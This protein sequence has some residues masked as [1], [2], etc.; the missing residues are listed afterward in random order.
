MVAAAALGLLLAS[1]VAKRFIA[2]VQTSMLHRPTPPDMVSGLT[3]RKLGLRRSEDR[4][5]LFHEERGDSQSRSS[6]PRF[7]SRDFAD[8]THCTEELD[9]IVLVMIPESSGAG[10]HPRDVEAQ[11]QE[12]PWWQGG[13]RVEALYVITGVLFVA[14]ACSA[15]LTA[16]VG[17]GTE[18][19][20]LQITT[21][22]FLG[23]DVLA[24]VVLLGVIY[25][26]SA[27]IRKPPVYE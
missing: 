27:V 11:R 23:L 4:L 21:F 12:F 14:T 16:T 6:S 15:I 20:V 5:P 9:E 17:S 25:W 8:L 1:L 13:R 2:C 24:A 10:D 7:A 26:R 3:G 18:I 22:A 19:D